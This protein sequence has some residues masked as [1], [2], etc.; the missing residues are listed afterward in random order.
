VDDALVVA[1]DGEYADSVRTGP[2][3]P[4]PTRLALGRAGT[5]TV[6]VEHPG[7]APAL[8]SGIRVTRGDCHVNT[9]TIRVEL[10]A[11]SSVSA[12]G[13]RIAD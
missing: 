5:Y 10:T 4:A 8:R 13:Q 11:T 6:H 1:R 3:P 7:Y 12:A 9:V 2:F